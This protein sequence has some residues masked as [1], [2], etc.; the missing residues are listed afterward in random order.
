M[1]VHLDSVIAKSRHL[2]LVRQCAVELWGKKK[3]LVS[4]STSGSDNKVTHMAAFVLTTLVFRA[5]ETPKKMD[6][7]TFWSLDKV[8]KDVSGLDG[9][10]ETQM[11][12]LPSHEQKLLEMIMKQSDDN[13]VN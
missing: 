1:T 6:E 5:N 2:S 4:N 9:L 10:N 7:L 8:K 12:S 3:R 13:I 11:K